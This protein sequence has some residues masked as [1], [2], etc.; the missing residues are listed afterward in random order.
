MSPRRVPRNHHGT[1]VRI[2]TRTRQ[3]LL[4]ENLFL[5]FPMWSKGDSRFRAADQGSAGHTGFD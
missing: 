3:N 5:E 1:F 2:H 4:K